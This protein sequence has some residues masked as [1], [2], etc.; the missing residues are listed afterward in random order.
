M[1]FGA[2]SRTLAEGLAGLAV[3]CTLGGL[4]IADAGPGIHLLEQPAELRAGDHAQI[5]AQIDEAAFC[6]LV[7]QAGTGKPLDSTSTHVAGRTQLTW[8]WRVPARTGPG[9]WQGAVECW[10]NQ[11][12]DVKPDDTSSIPGSLHGRKGLAARLVDAS[13]LATTV[14]PRPPDNRTF[15]QKADD[16]SSALAVLGVIFVGVTLLLSQRQTRSVRTEALIDRYADRTQ[17]NAWTRAMGFL[18]AADASVAVEQVRRWETAETNNAWMLVSRVPPRTGSLVRPTGGRHWRSLA[19]PH[20]P[21]DTLVTRTEILTAANFYEEI[22]ALSNLGKLDDDLVLRSFGLTMPQLFEAS[23]WW[24]CY[25]RQGKQAALRVPIVREHEDDTYAE[26]ERM[27]RRMFRQARHLGRQA[28]LNTNEGLTDKVR[29][30]CLPPEGETDSTQW[31]AYKALSLV[32]G[33]LLDD[34]KRGLDRL[35]AVLPEAPSRDVDPTRTFLIPP[36]RE[37]VRDAGAILRVILWIGARLEDKPLLILAR[38]LGRVV[39]EWDPRVK[40]HRRYHSLAVRLEHQ[41]ALDDGDT[42][43]T[44]ELVASA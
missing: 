6:M 9:N 4:A 30:L 10:R 5:V 36:W 14:T 27:V 1:G 37:H 39:A 22:A 43:K 24:I 32:V 33:G 26:W 35:E 31:D 40:L 20:G 13:G 2:T 42:G 25:Q 23:W 38:P 15:I 8:R 41:I 44:A 19:P 28:K 11:P 16:V 3:F 29:A 12:T 7:L 21:D 18:S 34:E 17:L